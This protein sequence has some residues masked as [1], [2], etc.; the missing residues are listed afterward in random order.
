MNYQKKNHIDFCIILAN[1][2]PMVCNFYIHL[3]LDIKRQSCLV[4]RVLNFM[5]ALKEVYVNRFDSCVIWLV[6]LCPF[7]LWMTMAMDLSSNGYIV[8]V[9]PCKGISLKSF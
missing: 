1:N 5:L 4:L 6:F 8:N 7:F 2:F 9:A 3:V